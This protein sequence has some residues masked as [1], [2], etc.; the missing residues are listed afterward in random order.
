MLTF[1]TSVIVFLVGQCLRYRHL[2]P[3]VLQID[4]S[5]SGL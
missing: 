5:A 4:F 2:L 1:T 3:R